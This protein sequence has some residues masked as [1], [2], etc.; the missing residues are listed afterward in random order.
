MK[1]EHRL[2]SQPPPKRPFLSEFRQMIHPTKIEMLG[3]WQAFFAQKSAALI[4]YFIPGD[5]SYLNAKTHKRMSAQNFLQS[6]IFFDL[7]RKNCKPGTYFGRVL[8]LFY[9]WGVMVLLVH[10][11][12][13]N[14]IKA[15][16]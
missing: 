14:Y 6:A 2:E 7:E 5:K 16:F 8:I 10:N 1:V 9:I 15:K 3:T 12:A 13:E 4:Y 11:Y